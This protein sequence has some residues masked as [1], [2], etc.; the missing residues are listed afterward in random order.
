MKFHFRSSYKKSCLWVAAFGNWLHKPVCYWN[1]KFLNV[2]MNYILLLHATK[3]WNE[4]GKTQFLST[5][6]ITWWQNPGAKKLSNLYNV[7]SFQEFP[8]VFSD[9]V[10]SFVTPCCVVRRYQC[11]GSTRTIVTVSPCGM[12]ESPTRLH[13]ESQCITSQSGTHIVVP[14]VKHD[15]IS[16]SAG[17]SCFIPK[18]TAQVA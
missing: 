5:S 14:V 13:R 12:M 2:V 11:C 8:V 1:L 17:L 7:M 4:D 10:F 6:K 15:T 16:W 18:E 9:S 3:E